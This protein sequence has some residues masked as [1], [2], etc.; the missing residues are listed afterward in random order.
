MKFVG[1]ITYIYT[2]QGFVY[3]ATVIDCFSRKVAGWSIADHMRTELVAAASTNAAATSL[4]EP[5][6]VFHSDRGSVGVFNWSKQHV[7]VELIVG[8]PPRLQRGFA[9]GV[10]SVVAC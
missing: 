2:W 9:I 10:V 7:A 4:I 3:L 5:E 6:A 1:D 8:V